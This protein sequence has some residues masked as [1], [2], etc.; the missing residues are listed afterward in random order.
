VSCTSSVNAQSE[1]EFFRQLTENPDIMDCC[2]PIVRIGF[3]EDSI[4]VISLALAALDLS[5]D[6]LDMFDFQMLDSTKSY[7]MCSKHWIEHAKKFGSIA[8]HV[9]DGLLAQLAYYIF[10]VVCLSNNWDYKEVLNYTK[11]ASNIKEQ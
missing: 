7:A 1:F 3:T 6:Y 9:N 4:H 10:R 11:T 8:V 2:G 5:I